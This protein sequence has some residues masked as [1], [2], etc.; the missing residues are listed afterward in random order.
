M[1]QERLGQALGLQRTGVTA[2]SIA[3]QGCRRDQIA[4]RTDYDPR[5]SPCRVA[6]VRVL[7]DQSRAAV[8]FVTEPTHTFVL[9][10]SVSLSFASFHVTSNP[11]K[12][13]ATSLR[14]GIQIQPLP[15]LGHLDLCV[16]VHLAG[17]SPLLLLRIDGRSRPL[18][19]GETTTKASPPCASAISFR[20]S[21]SS[22]RKN[23]SG[24]GR[25]IVAVFFFGLGTFVAG[26]LDPPRR[27]SRPA[28]V[29]SFGGARKSETESGDGRRA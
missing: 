20:R 25:L 1:T 14:S 23:G 10:H 12:A 2:A 7:P 17:C 18:H 8:P 5:P 29:P 16:E 28:S 27:L 9:S 11:Y 19:V 24:I 15:V 6:G 13:I 22:A 4:A 26:A 21:A 3:L